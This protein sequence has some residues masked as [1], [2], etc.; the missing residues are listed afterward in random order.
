MR[1]LPEMTLTRMEQM[2]KWNFAPTATNAGIALIP[3][4]TS[5]K[6][7]IFTNPLQTVKRE[8]LSTLSITS[9]NVGLI[10]QRM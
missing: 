7:L 5:L 6:A 4:A 2:P 8:D 9:D 10:V 1:L 3:K